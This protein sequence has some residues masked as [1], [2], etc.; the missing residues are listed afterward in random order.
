LKYC[1]HSRLWSGVLVLVLVFVLGSG[2]SRARPPDMDSESRLEKLEL[3]ADQVQAFE[4][5]RTRFRQE[6]I[7]VRKKMAA[8]RLE[9]RTLSDEERQGARGEEIK[10]EL[11]G[12]FLNGR[13]RALVYQ[14]EALK[15]LRADQKEKLPAGSDLGFRCHWGPF[16]GGGPGRD[17]HRNPPTPPSG[18][19]SSQP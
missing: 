6:L 15:I 3:T 7:Q 5:L 8:K 19:P 18:N 10:K 14:A 13:D 4:E 2:L 16:R 1:F 9:L 12:F 17:S 11:Q